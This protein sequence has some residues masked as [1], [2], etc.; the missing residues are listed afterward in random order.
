MSAAPT[1]PSPMLGSAPAGPAQQQSSSKGSTQGVPSGVLG[2]GAMTQPPGGATPALTWGE[3][4]PDGYGASATS[5]VLA[6]QSMTAVP[7]VEELPHMLAGGQVPVGL[8]QPSGPLGGPVQMSITQRVT[9]FDPEWGTPPETIDSGLLTWNPWRFVYEPSDM[10]PPYGSPLRRVMDA[11]RR[12]E[13]DD[14]FVQAYRDADSQDTWS[15]RLVL[16]TTDVPS[17]SGPYKIVGDVQTITDMTGRGSTEGFTVDDHGNPEVPA[18][19]VDDVQRHED[20]SQASDAASAVDVL[21]EF[22][23]KDQTVGDDNAAASVV[24]DGGAQQHEDKSKAPDA[25]GVDEAQQFYDEYLASGGAVATDVSKGG[26]GYDK[27]AA[28]VI[29]DGGAQQHEDKS[30]SVGAASEPDVVLGFL[31]DYEPDDAALPHG[32]IKGYEE[33]YPDI[34]TLPAGN[35]IQ[36]YPGKNYEEPK[37]YLVEAAAAAAAEA[38]SQDMGNFAWI[39]YLD[40]PVECPYPYPYM[41]VPLD[42]YFSG[43]WLEY[44]Y[45]P[46]IPLP[47]PYDEIPWQCGVPDIPWDY[48]GRPT[49]YKGVEN[50]W[51]KPEERELT[52]AEKKVK[53]IEELGDAADVIS[54]A[55][56]SFHN[57]PTDK[58]MD[59]KKYE[60]AR[61]KLEK[62]GVKA[63]PLSSWKSGMGI[64][65]TI[66]EMAALEGAVT[67][68]Q[69]NLVGAALAHP[70]SESERAIFEHYKYSLEMQEYWREYAAWKKKQDKWDEEEAKREALKDPILQAL[71]DI[72]MGTGTQEEKAEARKKIDSYLQEKAAEQAENKKAEESAGEPQEG[73]S[74]AVLGQE[75]APPVEPPTIVID[76][77]SVAP[78]PPTPPPGADPNF[79]PSASGSNAFVDCQRLIKGS[80][81]KELEAR[82]AQVKS[83][84]TELHL[85]ATQKVGAAGGI[86]A[87]A[88]W[89]LVSQA[90]GAVNSLLP[91]EKNG[92]EGTFAPAYLRA[93]AQK[94]PLPTWHGPTAW[95]WCARKGEGIL[96]TFEQ[97]VDKLEDNAAAA[98]FMIQIAGLMDSSQEDS[99]G[100]FGDLVNLFKL[101]GINP[102]DDGGLTEILHGA[103]DAILHP[104]P[105]QMGDVAGAV[106]GLFS[107]AQAHSADF[108][109]WDTLAKIAD[110]ALI[111]VG[112]GVVSI[113]KKGF[114]EIL[115]R[116]ARR[117]AKRK[118]ARAR[119]QA[120]DAA[121]QALDAR[122]GRTTSKAPAKSKTDGPPAK[123]Q[124]EHAS[125][126]ESVVGKGVRKRSPPRGRGRVVDHASD[127][128]DPV[129]ERPMADHLAGRGKT[130][131]RLPASDVGRTGDALVDGVPSEFK[132]L[133]PGATS[134]TVKTQVS[135]SIKRGGQA[136]DIYL[137]AR[138][139]GLAESEARRALARVG[140]PD[141]HR[142]RVDNITIVG[143]GYELSRTFP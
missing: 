121:Q 135:S 80:R 139:S 126:S 90:T 70:V 120:T 74:G 102:F 140:H 115:E 39:Y 108:E 64:Y 129:R 16:V 94:D 24:L 56:W 7:G 107:E 113:G 141:V 77:S 76:G 67:Q 54:A 38:A 91:R 19:F 85:A 93:L 131:E 31:A 95:D 92:H 111:F 32:V 128:F 17:L 40:L 84:I 50:W 9:G 6:Q 79:T 81:L 44:P 65:D 60:A 137:D 41:P 89:G 104:T 15:F 106:E 105:D 33:S 46:S 29:L 98:A 114:K 48:K 75:N 103:W 69:L 30:K 138:G 117:R 63:P 110:I 99:L 14:R 119:K 112:I 35:V 88:A 47:A 20:T 13:R 4:S 130:V 49:P 66:P 82:Y 37:D 132:M 122:A 27:A 87:T 2:L 134:G 11:Y 142:G 28:S 21:Q 116:V 68:L 61:R 136:R 127:P 58:E 34:P 3:P 8:R 72:V 86:N 36:G 51:K 143:N 97:L 118:L 25:S 83:A 59:R 18:H 62:A 23:D 57:D 100:E 55:G 43:R 12:L 26:E 101:R 133:D 22:Y 53:S 96:D 73:S 124:Q 42:D 71:L 125:S 5:G 109:I 1:A 45:E 10:T 78:T 123:Q 52:P